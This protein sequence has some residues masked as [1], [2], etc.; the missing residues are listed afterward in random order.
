MANRFFGYIRFT[1]N[2]RFVDNFN[3]FNDFSRIE[4]KAISKSVDTNTFDS[5]KSDRISVRHRITIPSKV[6]VLS[7]IV[8]IKAIINKVLNPNQIKT[9]AYLNYYFHPV[10]V[11]WTVVHV[12]RYWSLRNLD[13]VQEQM[14]ANPIEILTCSRISGWYICL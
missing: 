6:S 14:K 2:T 11:G 4:K 13:Y 7:E 3:N 5:L 10:V 1:Q 8:I 12:M 9:E